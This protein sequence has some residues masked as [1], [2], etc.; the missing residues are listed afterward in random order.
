VKRFTAKEERRRLTA[1]VYD[2]SRISAH[3]LGFEN[4]LN[5]FHHQGHGLELNLAIGLAAYLNSTIADRYFRRFSGHTQVN[6]TDLRRLYYPSSTM[7]EKL[8]GKLNDP[9]L[10]Q[11]E[12]DAMIEKDIF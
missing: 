1:C 9:G 5:Y 8:G 11:D 7:L 3:F 6:A 12:L 10:P 4:H 2:P